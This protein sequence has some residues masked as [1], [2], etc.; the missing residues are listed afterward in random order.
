MSGEVDRKLAERGV[1][2][3]IVKRRVRGQAELPPEVKATSR[4]KASVRVTVEHAFA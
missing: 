1:E 2:N 4:R 3:G